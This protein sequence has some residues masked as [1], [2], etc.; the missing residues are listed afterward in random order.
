MHRFFSRTCNLLCIHFLALAFAE[1]MVRFS[2]LGFFLFLA[3]LHC[4]LVAEPLPRAVPITGL[5]DGLRGYWGGT[6]SD[7]GWVLATAEGV[8]YQS[9]GGWD[10]WRPMSVGAP[11]RIVLPFANGGWVVG[12]RN[13]CSFVSAEGVET[14]LLTSGNFVAGAVLGNVAVVVGPFEAYAIGPAGV[15]ARQPL[16][17]TR[18]VV[19][20]HVFANRLVVLASKDEVFV[21]AHEHFEPADKT[22]RWAKDPGTYLSPTADGRY[23]AASNVLLL[24]SPNG[25]TTSLLSE[26]WPS[27]DVNFRAGVDLIGDSIVVANFYTGLTSYSLKGGERWQLDTVALGGNPV[28]LHSVG[29]WTSGWY[30]EWRSNG[31]QS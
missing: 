21:F 4:R 11:V 17:G 7:R 28:F 8:V 22:L 13:F 24:V 31:A 15:I 14:P 26:I 29:Q 16:S 27:L 10:L 20:A 2:K 12:G 5:P 1:F 9:N 19:S 18:V 3:F 23:L 6:L 25:E 30:R